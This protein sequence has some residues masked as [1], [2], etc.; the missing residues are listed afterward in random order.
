[1]PLAEAIAM[2]R[3]FFNY[4]PLNNKEK[5]PVIA[6]VDPADRDDMSLVSQMVRVAL[7][8]VGLAVTWEALQS[9]GW[10]ENDLAA[11]QQDW[12]ALW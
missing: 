12:E 4:L 7:S 5:P 9:P 10:K 1:M 3:R 2:L 8:G 11:L 6:A